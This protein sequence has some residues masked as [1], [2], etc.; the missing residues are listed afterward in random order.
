MTPREMAENFYGGHP[1]A[2]PLCAMILCGTPKE[3]AQAKAAL[4]AL[5]LTATADLEAELSRA[6]TK[7]RL[8][9]LSDGVKEAV[10]DLDRYGAGDF[11]HCLSTGIHKLD[12]R[13]RGG[14]QGGRMYLLGAPSGTG[15]TALIQQIVGAASEQGPVLFVSPEMTLASLVNRE[16]IRESR[17]PEWDRNPW[18]V[19][20]TLRAVAEEAHARAAAR[21][22]HEKRPIYVLD[23][24]DATM[25]EIEHAAH[26]IDG[27]TLVAIDYAQQVAGEID[28]RKPRYLQVGEVATRSVALAIKLNVPVVVASQVNILKEG[29]KKS[30]TFRESQI[31]DQKA[32]ATVVIE[33]VSD[34][35]PVTGFRH[36]S[37]SY[38]VCT[39]SRSGPGFRLRVDYKPDLYLMRDYDPPK[40]WSP[41][42]RGLPPAVPGD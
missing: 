38:L 32:W 11:T 8:K 3:I 1:A 14:L 30:Y 17:S 21:I 13:F 31:L 4:A 12:R 9:L 41:R 36:I 40:E 5:G 24:P 25:A 39:K 23:Q 6:V 42:G 16:I 34:E 26:A 10:R 37:E 18:E 20:P 7:G 33:L 15:K 2:E 35:D 27:L 22:L 28:D 19:N 29:A